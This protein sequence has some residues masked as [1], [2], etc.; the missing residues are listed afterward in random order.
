MRAAHGVGRRAT[1][2]SMRHTLLLLT[3]LAAFGT[4][5]YAEVL[6]CAD[7]AGSV[8]YTDDACPAGSRPVGRVALPEPAPPPSP[9][10][11]E[12]R[13]QAQTDSADRASQLQREAAEAAARA[14]Q[15]A[16]SG[17]IVIDPNR[18]ANNAG[19][20]SDDRWRARSDDPALADD[21]FYPYPGIAG[22][23]VRPRNL[24]QRMRNC[25]AGGCQDT[26]GNHYNRSG[27]LDRYRSLDGR[28]CQPVGTTTICR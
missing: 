15:P 4:V 8:S 18:G 27:Q 26:Q 6:R 10:E 17:P 7:A 22:R 25:D 23:P 16:P 14:P 13:R 28:T 21:G 1:I 24:G 12:R 5:S 19:R 2:T 20:A 3:V 11:A 9:E